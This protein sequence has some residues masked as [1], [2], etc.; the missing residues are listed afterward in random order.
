MADDEYISIQKDNESWNL[1]S[2]FLLFF[3]RAK[4]KINTYSLVL[5]CLGKTFSLLPTLTLEKNPTQLYIKTLHNADKPLV[6]RCFF[7]I[8]DYFLNFH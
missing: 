7:I 2:V 8:I 4:M 5:T 3:E 6:H 1:V